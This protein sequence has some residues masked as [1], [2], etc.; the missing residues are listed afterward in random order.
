[1]LV[2]LAIPDAAVEVG[3]LL[4]HLCNL[5]PAD[6]RMCLTMGAR[7]VM[8]VRVVVLEVRLLPRLMPLMVG[9]GQAAVLATQATQVLPGGHLPPSLLH[10]RGVLVEMV[11]MRGQGAQ[12]VM[13]ARALITMALFV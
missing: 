8:V 10:F 11:E 1:M 5:S 2:M 3:A 6:R 12:E 4:V 9:L 7:E 13:V